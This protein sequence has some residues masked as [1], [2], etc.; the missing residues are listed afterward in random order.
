[1]ESKVY[2]GEYTLSHWIKLMLKKNIILPDYQ[3]SFIW[4]KKDIKRFIQS[5]KEHQFVQPITIAVNNLHDKNNNL[6]IDGQQ[7]LTSILLAYLGSMPNKEKFKNS[8]DFSSEDDSLNDDKSDIENNKSIEWTMNEL[9]NLKFNS[10][11]ELKN[12]LKENDKYEKLDI[13]DLNKHFFDET[14]LGFSYI[15][16]IEKDTKKIQEGYSKLFRSMNYFGIKL[17]KLE[18]RRSLYFMNDSMRKFFDGKDDN[19]KDVL[20]DIRIRED[21]LSNKI[22]FVKYLSILSQYK[23]LGTSNSIMKGYS[24]YSSRELFYTDYVFFQLGLDQDD[25][26]DKFDD[27]KIKDLFPNNEW[28]KRFHVLRD[29]ILKLRPY[30]LNENEKAFPSWINADY[31]LFGV[32]YYVLFLG[33]TIIESKEQELATD[34][35]KRITE[36]RWDIKDGKEEASNYARNANRLG[37]VRERVA[38]SIEIYKNYVQ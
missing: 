38:D 21:M 8:E 33:R 36:K 31:W 35:N 28:Q 24:A 18:S 11:E 25:R 10:P 14:F 23:K 27:C 1:M 3:R 37:N 17:S 2:Y 30:M 22:D 13:Q 5:L 19:D 34:I 29:T 20:C 16:P 12:I 15:V 32:I 6:I 7:R 26:E 4:D 9:Q